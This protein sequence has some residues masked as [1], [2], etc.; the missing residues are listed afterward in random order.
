[1]NHTVAHHY[2]EPL[3]VGAEHRGFSRAQ[4][5][6]P[7]AG[8]AASLAAIEQGQ[9]LPVDDYV[10]LIQHVWAITADET[11]GY[12]ARALKPGTFAMMC[13]ACIGTPNL[14]KAFD[15]AG[16]FFSLV[17][18]DIQL[19]LTE[20]DSEAGFIFSQQPAPPAPLSSLFY[21]E[22][23]ALIFIRWASWLID[24]KLLV[25]RIDFQAPSPGPEAEQEAEAV[26]GIQPHYN[27]AN[28]Q[29]TIARRFLDERIQQTETSLKLFLD[30]APASLLSHYRRDAS[31]SAAVRRFLHQTVDQGGTG[32][33]FS[34]EQ[35]A[36]AL[37]L[38]SQTL[39]RRLKEE[40]NSFQ[41]IKDAV[42]C[43]LAIHFLLHDALP[44]QDIAFKMGF[45]DPSVFYKAFKRWTGLTPGAYKESKLNK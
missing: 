32:E 37:H 26:F 2:V 7:L 25:A 36:D 39:R 38:T 27:Q 15:R 8:K 14:R 9:R 34:L 1:M 24:K 22:T 18:D 12:G 11:G 16:R 20:N 4:L 41:E 23:L 40:G 17:S 10:L 45:S 35:V 31:V 21:L 19:R 5:L 43:R 6:A 13:H 28:N 3:L 44:A 42:R 33:E 29:I 30:Q